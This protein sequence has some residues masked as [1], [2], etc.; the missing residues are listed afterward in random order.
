[1]YLFQYIIIKSMFPFFQKRMTP[2][3]KLYLVSIIAIIVLLL[4]VDGIDARRKKPSCRYR[5]K[6]NRC[7]DVIPREQRRIPKQ[8]RKYVEIKK[9]CASM[10]GVCKISAKNRKGKIRCS[11]DLNHDQTYVDV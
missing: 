6:L 9:E 8:C 1:M 10:G 3:R 5:T 11:C 7:V 4:I 2:L